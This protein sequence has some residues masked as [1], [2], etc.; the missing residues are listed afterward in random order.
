MK[1]VYIQASLR[2]FVDVVSKSYLLDVSDA[3]FLARDAV[4]KRGL[5]C[6]PVSGRLSRWCIV[7]TRQKMSSNFFVSPVAPSF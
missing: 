1:F 3:V 6:R 7:S 5:C 2:L 4:R